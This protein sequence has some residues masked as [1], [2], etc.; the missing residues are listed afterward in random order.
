MLLLFT[1]ALPQSDR[2]I[3]GSIYDKYGKKMYSAAFHILKNQS[4]AEDA[5]QNSFLKIAKKLRELDGKDEDALR[6]YVLAIATNEAYNIIRKRHDDVPEDELPELSDS[7]DF[8]VKVAEGAEFELAVTAMR[9]MDEKYR[10]PLYLRYVMDF[11]AKEVASQL[12]RSEATVRSQISR[13]LAMLR[14]TLKEAGYE[15]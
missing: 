14:K 8:T 11:S 4:D 6:G 1:E 10:A 7:A 2:Q 12:G 15:S 3:L 9:G 5:A 13:G